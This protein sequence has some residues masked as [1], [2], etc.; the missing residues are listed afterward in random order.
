MLPCPGAWWE[1][2]GAVG[3]VRPVATPAGELRAQ[4]LPAAG[5][6]VYIWSPAALGLPELSARASLCFVPGPAGNRPVRAPARVCVWKVTESTLSTLHIKSREPEL[7]GEKT[8]TKIS[9]SVPSRSQ[10]GERGDSK[11]REETEGQTARVA[12]RRWQAS[13]HVTLF[14]RGG[15]RL[16][17]SPEGLGDS[18]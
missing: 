18:Q 17:R 7:F 6:L 4:A 13:G 2:V 14:P 8:D 9:A 1:L 15:N 3:E 16:R 10:L 5:S 12:G 11:G